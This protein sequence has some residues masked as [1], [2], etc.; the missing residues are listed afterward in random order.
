MKVKIPEIQITYQGIV[1][2]EERTKIPW[3]MNMVWF[4]WSVRPDTIE[5]QESLFVILVNRQLQAIGY[6][7][8]SRGGLAGTIVDI[9][10]ILGVALK[11][12]AAGIIVAHNHPSWNTNPSKHD[13]NITEKLKNACNVIEIEL[14]DH[15]IITPQWDF[16][17]FAQ[18]DLL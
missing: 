6:K 16:F 5:Y 9:K 7:E 1:P 10:Q 15:L 17:S 4:L 13:V 8:M 3:V 12:N 11:A 14:F 2:F 18:N